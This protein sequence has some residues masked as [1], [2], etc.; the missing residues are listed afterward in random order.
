MKSL[1]PAVYGA[2]LL[3][4]SMWAATA[5][6]VFIY[7]TPTPG[8]GGRIEFA[9]DASPPFGGN[10]Y[11]I[12]PTSFITTPSGTFFYGD[13]DENAHGLSGP[14]SWDPTA[15]IF[16]HVRWYVGPPSPTEGAPV[17][18][19]FDL[20]A[21]SAAG[22][23]GLH[24]VVSE[25]VSASPP[26]FYFDD[27]GRWVPLSDL[28]IECP[29]DQEAFAT[30]SAG[31]LVTY[32]GAVAE[33]ATEISYSQVSGSLFALGTTTITATASDEVGN[34]AAC[35]FEVS[36]TYDW[37]GVLSP[38]NAD[39]SSVFKAGRTVPVKFQLA[40][41]SAGIANAI[42]RLSY[43][44]ISGNVPG[45]VNEADSTAAATS[46]NLFRYDSSNR[47]YIFNWS[48]KGLAPGTYRLNLDLGDGQVRTVDL[49]LR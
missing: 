3:Y 38:V 41:S 37:S 29:P 8:F 20:Q 40:G 11:S 21:Y 44:R 31:A 33:G 4:T 2:L 18:G 12:L 10:Q 27:A 30:T 5:G 35:E 39:G 7:Q 45:P 19:Q 16:L 14:P 34:I 22:D 23:P 6:S 13:P 15:I 48:T 43:A 24:F 42:A 17:P 26:E 1:T 47:E 46:G 28:T 25:R 9:S 49:S 32:P 36:V